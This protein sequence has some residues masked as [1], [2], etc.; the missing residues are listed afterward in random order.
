MCRF[1]P[2]FVEVMRWRKKDPPDC[3]MRCRFAATHAPTKPVR[4]GRS[5]LAWIPMQGKLA[6][7][8]PI[9]S[10]ILYC[11]IVLVLD[12]TPRSA[13]VPGW[14]YPKTSRKRLFPS[15]GTAASV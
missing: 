5:D 8:M 2:I 9:C 15:H 4:G 14:H 12:F 10:K 1:W 11:V 6:N 3:T 13:E 7:K